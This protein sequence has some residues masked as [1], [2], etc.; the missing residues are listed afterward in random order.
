MVTQ[1]TISSEEAKQIVAADKEARESQAPATSGLQINP[2]AM[3][4]S[5]SIQGDQASYEHHQ[6]VTRVTSQDYVR[7]GILGSLGVGKVH[8]N[9]VVQTPMG[10]MSLDMAHK[11]GMVGKNGDG[12]YY[13]L[14][15]EKKNDQP[16]SPPKETLS[17]TEEQPQELPLASARE[18]LE[19]INT[20]VP[21]HYR[22]GIMNAALKHIIDSPVDD[23][24]NSVALNL[25]RY[26]QELGLPEEALN[27]N[28]DAVLRG[29]QTQADATLSKLG[30]DTES[31]YEFL[32]EEHPDK[33]KQAIQHH[34]WTRNPS[35]WKS[36]VPLYRKSVMP[37][38]E[39]LI[40]AGYEV[41]KREG[42]SVINIGGIQMTVKSA[43]KAGLI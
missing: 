20:H 2:N 25:S 7:P 8:P 24:G 26:A 43:A 35:V 21:E 23:E 29:F 3:S 42:E 16:Q 31:F 6:G 5:L 39:A 1:V 17:E 34:Y 38:D 19:Q 13:E 33:L 9:A 40:G 28:V 41:G 37:T 18:A 22:D 32:R 36:L 11:F 14:G 30:V 15:G 27:T 12:S 4:G 10:E